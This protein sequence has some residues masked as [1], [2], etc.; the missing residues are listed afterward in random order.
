MHEPRAS[1]HLLGDVVLVGRRLHFVP[2]VVTVLDV[3]EQDVAVFVSNNPRVSVSAVTTVDR[4]VPDDVT[5]V[6]NG[7][8]N[9]CRHILFVGEQV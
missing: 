5:R 3:H 4:L 6:V 1:L 9:R 7:L 2:E 8:Q